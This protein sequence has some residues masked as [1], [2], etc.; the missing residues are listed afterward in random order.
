MRRYLVVYVTHDCLKVNS[1]NDINKNSDETEA[2]TTVTDNVED[3]T[4][5]V[6][7]S[8]EKNGIKTEQTTMSLSNKI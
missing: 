3:L 4:I 2:D 1:F 7:W 5:T 8:V 6:T